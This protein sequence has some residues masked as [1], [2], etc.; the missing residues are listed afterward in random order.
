MSNS[1]SA[2]IAFG[3]L[4]LRLLSRIALIDTQKY[5]FLFRGVAASSICFFPCGIRLRYQRDSFFHLGTLLEIFQKICNIA[6]FPFPFHHQY[7]LDG[8]HAKTNK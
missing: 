1:L 3:K 2:V 6:E 7:D 4:Q 5:K 8:H